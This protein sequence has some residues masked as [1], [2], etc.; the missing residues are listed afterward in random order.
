MW[1]VE[2]L[3]KGECHEKFSPVFHLSI[4]FYS[5]YYVNA[6]LSKAKKNVDVLGAE[7]RDKDLEEALKMVWEHKKSLLI[8]LEK[9]GKADG[10]EKWREKEAKDLSDLVQR[11]F[12]YTK[13]N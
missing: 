1:S 12:R 6:Q 5:R 8:D 9:L 2:Y 7:Q 4:L 13:N 3:K 10:H 11:R